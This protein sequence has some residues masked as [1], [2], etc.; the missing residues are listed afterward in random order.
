MKELELQFRESQY[1]FIDEQKRDIV[2][3]RA[4]NN[5]GYK[6]F[7][8]INGQA[9]SE[10][11]HDQLKCLTGTKAGELKGAFWVLKVIK[12]MMKQ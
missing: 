5:S 1:K 11:K 2:L 10:R 9:V 6:Y 4:Y 3:I 8:I 12:E 7:L